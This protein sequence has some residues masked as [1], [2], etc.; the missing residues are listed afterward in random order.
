MRLAMIV[1]AVCVPA[2]VFSQGAQARGAI[3][4]SDLQSTTRIIGLLGVELGHVV[5]VE[6]RVI[7]SQR[8]GFDNVLEMVSTDAQPVKRR[9]Q[10]PFEIAA[11]SALA[12]ATLPVDQVPS[13]RVYET[14]GMVGVP[15]D[16]MKEI[17]AVQ[18]MS[19]QFMTSLIILRQL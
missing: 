4:V 18:A 8:L 17:Q 2:F 14:G 10:M 15:D 3:S 12:G 6:G 16:A 19:W 13:L 9:F 5:T 11:G 1:A 7:H